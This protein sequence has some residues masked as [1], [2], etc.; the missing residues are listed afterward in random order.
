MTRTREPSRTASSAECVTKS[1]VVPD[2]AASVRTSSWRRS[3]VSAS[4]AANGSSIRSTCGSPAS[5]RAMATRCCWPPESS[6]VR[7]PAIPASP[8]RASNSSVCSAL[9]SRGTPCR[10]RANA[11]LPPAVRQGNSLGCWKTTPVARPG[12]GGSPRTVAVPSEGVTKPAA[13]RSRVVFPQPDG[14]TSTTNSP[15]PASRETSSTA[16]TGALAFP[17]RTVIPCSAMSAVSAVSAAWNSAC[18]TGQLLH[19]ERLLEGGLFRDGVH[20]LLPLEEDGRLVQVARELPGAPAVPRYSGP[21]CSFAVSST[22]CASCFFASAGGMLS[23]APM[24]AAAFS[25]SDLVCSTAWSCVFSQVVTMSGCFFAKAS[26]TTPRS[27]VTLPFPASSRLVTSV[28]PVFWISLSVGVQTYAA[29]MSPRVQAASASCGWR[30][31]MFTSAGFTPASSSAASSEKWV[32]EPKGRR[33]S[34][35]SAPRRSRCPSWRP[36]PRCRR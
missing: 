3:R 9:C 16:T 19:R 35:P 33:P 34:S 29:S 18:G 1:T 32:V 31:T 24:D 10:A 23:S 11:M 4:S 13:I 14:P 30:S 12:T 27:A 7:R 15:G 22:S 25:G 28:V 20:G 2:V 8:T 21:C 26:V 5:A 36:R 17:Y 6:H